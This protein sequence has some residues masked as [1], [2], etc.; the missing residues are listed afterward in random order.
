VILRLA[1]GKWSVSPPAA[2]PPQDHAGLAGVNCRTA[3][4]CTTVGVHDGNSTSHEFSV[5][6]V[7]ASS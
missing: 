6:L 5:P 4:A 7:E 2:L 3:T 1:G